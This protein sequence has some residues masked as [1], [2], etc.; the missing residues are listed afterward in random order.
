MYFI[1]NKISK[2]PPTMLALFSTFLFKYFPIVKPIIVKIKQVIE[3]IR[4]DRYVYSSVNESPRPTVKLS[5][6]TVIAIII[7]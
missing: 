6:L 7:K 2:I 4:L 1:D 3:N 5:I